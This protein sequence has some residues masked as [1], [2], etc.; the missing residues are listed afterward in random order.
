MRL[1]LLT[2]RLVTSRHARRR[3]GSLHGDDVEWVV[4]VNLPNQSVQFI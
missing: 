2:L 1:R 4:A 3:Y